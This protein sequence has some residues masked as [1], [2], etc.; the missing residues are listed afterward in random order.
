M[1]IAV[2]LADLPPAGRRIC[3]AL[4]EAERTAKAAGA[5]VGFPPVVRPRPLPTGAGPVAR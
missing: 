4:I 2:R 1:T 5:A 3:A